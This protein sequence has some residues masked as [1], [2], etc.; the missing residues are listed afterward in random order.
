MHSAFSFCCIL[1]CVVIT[2]S[3]SYSK[4]NADDNGFLKVL[5]F[6]S[7]RSGKDATI[8]K[9][10]LQVPSSGTHLEIELNSEKETML[11]KAESVCFGESTNLKIDDLI[12]DC[13]PKIRDQLLE[14]IALNGHDK[15]FKIGNVSNKVKKKVMEIRPIVKVNA[16]DLVN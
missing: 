11:S 16:Y 6:F 14:W 15:K 13:I 2:I 1:L 8:V 3:Q 5:R 9:V 10:P 7:G 4:Q 12:F